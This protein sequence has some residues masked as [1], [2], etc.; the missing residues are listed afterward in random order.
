[1]SVSTDEQVDLEHDFKHSVPCQ[2]RDCAE[3][4]TWS[5]RKTCPRRCGG[6]IHV[7]SQHVG[8]VYH[9]VRGVV[10][11]TVLEREEKTV[12]ATCRA[13]VSP[14]LLEIRSL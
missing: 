4:A 10:H 7:C 5:Q 3:G 6:W 8:M 11:H 1:M 13:P 14:P 2:F 12:C 9:R